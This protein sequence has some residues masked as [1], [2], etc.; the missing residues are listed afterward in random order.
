MAIDPVPTFSLY[1]EPR[2]SAGDRFVHLEP[3]SH[4]SRPSRWTIRA[5]AHADLVQLFHITAGGGTLTAEA[6]AL[7]FAA[8]CLLAMPEGI[9]HALSLAAESEGQVLTIATPYRA[10][11][12]AR[13]AD[14]AALFDRPAVAPLAVPARRAVAAGL[15]RLGRA[16][17]D[18][19]PGAAAAAD[20]ALVLL[21]V[22]VRRAMGAAADPAPVAAR[23]AA[24]VTRYR[25]R[26]EER[27][28]LREPVAAHA[29]AL[30]VSPGR[31]RA[32][33]AAVAR[34]SP[35]GLIDARAMVEARRLLA[36][37]P[38]TV[39]EVGHA[40]G[41]ADPAY[42]SRFFARHAG[43]PPGA[44]RPARPAGE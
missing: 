37:T 17:A 32:A 16:L 13:D 6:S 5:H 26:V 35:M 23:P 2:R 29:A 43:H 10:A 42:F 39:A 12:V 41:F 9:A 4:R 20:A 3:L 38:L 34:T 28:R 14:L 22:A 18:T 25:R 21:L 33:C 40:L 7:P 19:A 36:Y 44:M 30:G 11:L 1:G 15:A 24:L 27:F 31:L 8:P